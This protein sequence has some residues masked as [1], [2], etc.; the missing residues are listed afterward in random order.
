MVLPNNINKIF[1]AFI[2]IALVAAFFGGRFTTLIFAQNSP[3][4]PGDIPCSK[5]DYPEFSSLRPYQANPCNKNA[6]TALFCGNQLVLQDHVSSSE[7]SCSISGGRINCTVTKTKT[8]AINLSDAKLP[9]LGNTD[10][11]ENSTNSS[12]SLNDAEKINQ[13]VSWYLSGVNNKAESKPLNSSS[14][15]DISKA[16]N[17]SGPLNKLLPWDVQA[18][19]RIATINSAGDTQHNQVVAC[20]SGFLSGSK[21]EACTPSSGNLLRLDSWKGRIG[22]EFLTLDTTWNQR[23]PPLRENFKTDIEYQKAYNEWKGESCVIITVPILN[24]KKLACI[25]NPLRPNIW[26]DAF[27]H[28][29]MAST[30]DNQGQ[31][32]T[33]AIAVQPASDNLEVTDVAFNNQQPAPLF[34]AHTEEAAGLSALLQSTY[35]PQGEAGSGG[36]SGVS[37][38][39]SSCD[40]LNI[41]TNPGDNLFA[42]EIKGDLTY[43]AKFSCPAPVQ[44][45]GSSR[46]HQITGGYCVSDSAD[47]NSDYGS[48]YCGSG[49]KCGL[50]CSNIE[51]SKDVNV[52][53]S[54]LTESPKADE[55]WSRTVAGPAGIFKRIFP[56]VGAGS[57]IEGIL[58]IPAATKVSYTSEDGTPVLAGN[59]E[60]Q[61]SGEGAELYFPHI[62]GVYEYFLKGIQTI[63]RPKGFGEQIISGEPATLISSGEINCNVNASPISLK[64]A[65][66][67]DALEALALRWSP[68]LTGNHVQDCY[69]DV[70]QRAK[71]AGVNPGL[72]LWLWLHESNASNYNISKE[73]FGVHYGQPEGFVAQ[74]TA[75]L[76]RAKSDTYRNSGSVCNGAA[77]ND[78]QAWAYV[79]RSG[80]CDGNDP[81]AK[82]FYDDLLNGWGAVNPGCSLPSSPTDLSCPK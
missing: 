23:I 10:D 47:C 5:T 48:L 59:P 69:Y 78:L 44:D 14:S 16:L 1:Y 39:D 43:T 82:S 54:L 28:I 64:G 13:Y 49:Q 19:N 60:N 7:G 68:G 40:L 30:E 31:V 25:D 74:I 38:S 29:P 35:L 21:L 42:G 6:P 50:G 34:F 24:V 27:S 61:R 56:R 18:S 62:G 8:I 79:Y 45:D 22:P 53:L 15:E 9:I 41:R 46:C 36:V 55:I 11:T 4:P 26:A 58:D 57:A 67:K 77:K 32:E 3:I 12:G 73:D 71:S 33:S 81:G 72:A 37:P 2:P 52:N 66:G 70:I 51:C 76:A 20:S 17:F 75:F 63:L 80:K 65:L